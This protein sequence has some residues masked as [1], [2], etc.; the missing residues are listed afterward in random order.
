[1]KRDKKDW[2]WTADMEKAFVDLKES[3]TTAA[4]LT[5]DSTNC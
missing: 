3:F 1:M 4:I 5:Q 2:E